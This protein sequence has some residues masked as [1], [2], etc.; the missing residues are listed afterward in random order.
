VVSLSVQV[1]AQGLPVRDLKQGDF[2]VRDE[3][4]PQDISGFSFG[5]Q[6]LDMML[7][8]DAAPEMAP[9]HDGVK[10]VAERAISRLDAH[11]RIGIIEFAEKQVLTLGLASVP[12]MIVTA[13]R[14]LQPRGGD[15]ELN[16]P[17]A[18]AALYLQEHARPEATR[19]I[20]LLTDNQGRP[21]VAD[22]PTRD[23][24]WQSTVVLNGLLSKREPSGEADVRRLID[25]TGGEALAMDP[26]NVPLDQVL[27]D[28]HDRYRITYRAPGGTPRSIRKVSV[29][30]AGEAKA[31][32]RDA[33]IRFPGAYVVAEP[34]PA[35]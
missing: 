28:L 6:P 9:F 20:V 30:L 33:K 5:S 34:R 17:V 23:A 14:K 12:E 8:L 4:T 10:A 21:G 25:A 24:L 26:A 35:R 15:K 31:R 18:L 29:E 3:G 22:R 11:D 13:I 1:L 27:R 2:L 19:A 32:I 7:L 16:S